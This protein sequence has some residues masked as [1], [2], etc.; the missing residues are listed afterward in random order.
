[1]VITSVVRI[2]LPFSEGYLQKFIFLA[3]Q[4]VCMLAVS[5]QLSVRKVHINQPVYEN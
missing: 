2:F 5:S 3:R 4:K 1:M